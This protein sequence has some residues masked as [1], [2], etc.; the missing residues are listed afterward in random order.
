MAGLGRKT[1]TAGEVLTAANVNGYL[2]DQSVMVFADSTARGSAIP[3]PTEGMVTYLE[4]TNALEF[5]NGAAFAPVSN[6]GDITAVTAGT[7]LTGGGTAG[8]VTLDVDI[9]AVVPITTEG[10]LVIGDA[11]GD[12]IRIGIGAENTVLTSNGT[13][14]TWE[15]AGGGA[16]AYVGTLGGGTFTVSIPTGVYSYN[17]LGTF[18]LENALL[19]SVTSGMFTLTSTATSLSFEPVTSS[20][21]A[22][23]SGFGASAIESLTFGNDVYVAGGA[24]GTLTTSSDA[25]TWTTRTSGFGSTT[26]RVLGFGNGIYLAGGDAGT[27]TTSTDAITWTT[28]TSGFGASNIRALT[29]GNSVYVAGGVGGT[30]TTSTDAVTWTTRTSNFGGSQ[31]EVLAFGNG[32]YLVGGE[33]GKLNTSTDG[34]TWTTRTS[35]FGT[36]QINALGFGNG[37]YVA[38][39]NQGVLTT[40]TDGITWTSR[41]S[42]FSS[43]SIQSLTFGNEIFVIGGGN[44]LIRFSKDGTTWSSISSNFGTTSVGALTFGNNIYLAG[45]NA[46]T[47]TAGQSQ[48]PALILNKATEITLT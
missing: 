32:L 9:S 18:A 8:D 42:T 47:L 11:S 34:I 23:T 25:I 5:Y 35:G 46:G 37:V 28:R 1:F 26:I 14:A 30:I 21:T 13:T 24:A 20:F 33:G 22:R 38:G 19:Q 48:A 4:D 27:L 15:A 44:G 2:M 36:T 7:G 39:G 41:T 16:T 10:D 40:S 43:N 29:F 45:G 31:I 6:P 12:P 3:T 17:S